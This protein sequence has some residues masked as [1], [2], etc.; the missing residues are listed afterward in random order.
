M[1]QA[2]GLTVAG[3]EPELQL[4]LV[5]A[6]RPAISVDNN[7]P[8]HYPLIMGSG[9]LSVKGHLYLKNRGLSTN[10]SI[11][12]REYEQPLQGTS[13]NFLGNC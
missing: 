6:Q 3:L 4:A 9:R 12:Y 7:F 2:V 13:G 5:P 10:F 8:P 11:K 1:S